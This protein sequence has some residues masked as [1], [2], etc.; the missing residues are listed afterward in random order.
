MSTPDSP[1]PYL[2]ENALIVQKRD[3]E[4]FVPATVDLIGYLARD[5]KPDYWRI[6]FNDKLDSYVRV[7][8]VSIVSNRPHPRE[9]GPVARTV[10]R[11]SADQEL[12][13]VAVA[14]QELQAGFLG[15][16]FVTKLSPGMSLPT[17]GSAT[18]GTSWPCLV[19]TATIVVITIERT[20]GPPA[21]TAAET[22]NASCCL[23]WTPEATCPYEP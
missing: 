20:P 4:E 7:P 14:P 23:C 16:E 8:E 9:D 15:G 1:R 19:V 5:A 10:V 11:V 12:N 13:H 6:Y 22:S 17:P 2:E 21:F 3:V 18:A